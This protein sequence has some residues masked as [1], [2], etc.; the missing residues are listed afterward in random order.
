[1]QGEIDRCQRWTAFRL[2]SSSI[3]PSSDLFANVFAAAVIVGG[4]DGSGDGDD[5]FLSRAIPLF[6]GS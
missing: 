6:L 5:N 2:L 3:S 4:A 1:M